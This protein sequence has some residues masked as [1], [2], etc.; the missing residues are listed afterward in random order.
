MVEQGKKAYLFRESGSPLYHNWFVL[1]YDNV[2]YAITPPIHDLIVEMRALCARGY[3][4]IDKDVPIDKIVPV[5]D[6]KKYRQLNDRDREEL[7]AAEAELD[8]SLRKLR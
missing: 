1:N 2:A 8:E 7:K 5:S 6:R 4:I 3:Q